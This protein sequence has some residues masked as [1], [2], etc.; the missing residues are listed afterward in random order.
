MKNQKRTDSFRMNKAVYYL[1]VVDE[2]SYHNALSLELNS[3]I[4]ENDHF[5]LLCAKPPLKESIAGNIRIQVLASKEPYSL[6]FPFYSTIA[7]IIFTVIM[8]ALF[9]GLNLS[10]TSVAISELYVIMRMGDSYQSR[11]AKNIIPVRLHLNWLICSFATANAI[12][13]CATSLLIENFLQYISHGSLPFIAL[14]LIP[15]IITVVFSELLPL[16]ICNRRGLCIASKTRYVTW[17]TMIILSPIAWPLSKI[18]DATLGAQG[19]E[20]YDRSKIEFLILEAA[21]ASSA[22]FSEILKNTINLPRIRVGNLMTKIDEAFLLSTKD[23]LDNKL[24]LSI[25]EKGYTRIPVYEGSKRSKVIAV[26]NVKDLI[27]TDFSKNVCVIDVLKKL[28]YLKQVRF[29]CE[30]MQVNPLMYEMEGQNFAFEPKGYISHLAMVVK[31]DSKSYSLI[32][33]ITLEDI[34]EEIF[35]QATFDWLRSEPNPLPPLEQ[36]YH[37]QQALENYSGFKGLSFNIDTM[38]RLF[39]I[40][41]IHTSSNADKK[42]CIYK[43]GSLYRSVTVMLRGEAFYTDQDGCR[44][45]ATAAEFGAEL[46]DQIYLRYCNRE[47]FV[48]LCK[49]H[50]TPQQTIYIEPP[51][52]YI[53]ITLRAIIDTLQKRERDEYRREISEA[54]YLQDEADLSNTQLTLSVTDAKTTQVRMVSESLSTLSTTGS[55]HDDEKLSE[56]SNQ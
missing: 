16:A 2:Y 14:T 29:V 17:L 55:I 18:L 38:R 24:I 32:G 20:V 44:K 27:S 49:L 51:F 33:L 12:T 34:I 47:N 56:S 1:N 19:C 22:V 40:C 5:Y 28:N 13:N 6:P 48:D 7:L 3:G 25:V 11:L 10:F 4:P 46:I 42:F 43:K 41:E 30:E 21:R 52:Q 50:F 8:A 35:D 26:L 9:A 15:C 39:N 54:K 36:I 45:I 31:Y 53:K 37:I 23:T